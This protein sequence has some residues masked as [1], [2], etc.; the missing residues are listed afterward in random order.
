MSFKEKIIQTKVPQH[1]AVIMDGN[2]RWAKKHGMPRVFGHRQ[3]VASVR[4]ITE[5]AAEI[6]V[7]Y[8]TIY[9]F[10]TENWN[11]PTTEIEAL[12]TLMVSSISSE[13]KSLKENNVR[14]RVVGNLDAL[15]GLVRNKILAA[16]EATKAST[17]L[18]LIVAF[19]YSSTW[20]VTE[21]V[22]KV[23]IQIAN[24]VITTDEINFE[25]I[26]Q[27]LATAEYPNPELL[28][29]TS[30]EYR[31]SNF[32]LLQLAYAELYFTD[33]FWPDFGKEEFFKAICDFQQRERRF[34]KISEQIKPDDAK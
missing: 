10:S 7:K 23:A 27:N 14:L 5:A 21:M 34:G 26:A 25:L 19:S 18:T 32:L 3:G 33:V 22:K 11:R 20:E 24:N 8:L 2:G 13:T 1:V 28:I 9:A 6:G 12:M 31:L 16:V 30:G 29:R 17:G 4:R 15:S